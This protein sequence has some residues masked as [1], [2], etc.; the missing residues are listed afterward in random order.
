MPD[1]ISRLVASIITNTLL[2]DRLLDT[3]DVDEQ[4]APSWWTRAGPAPR[5]SP[6][7]PWPT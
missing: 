1:E 7:R 4:V 2:H 3:Y 5:P 6:R